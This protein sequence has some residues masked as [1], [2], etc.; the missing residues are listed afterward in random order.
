MLER[1]RGAAGG[2][3]VGFSYNSWEAW[4]GVKIF[5]AAN[6]RYLN[7]FCGAIFMV[8]LYF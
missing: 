3:K 5:N 4:F 1:M 6:N 8:R 2:H 7:I